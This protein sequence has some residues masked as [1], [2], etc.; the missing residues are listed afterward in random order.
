MGGPVDKLD[1]KQKEPFITNLGINSLWPSGI[2][3][4]SHHWF[5]P[6]QNQVITWTNIDWL[7]NWPSETNLSE[8]FYKLMHIFFH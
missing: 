5:R 3:E 6:V 4:P 8:I 1:I 7:S 2:S